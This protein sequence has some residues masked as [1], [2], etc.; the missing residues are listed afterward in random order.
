MKSAY[1]V[2]FFSLS[3]RSVD[4]GL[5]PFWQ[6]SLLNSAYATAL[7]LYASESVARFL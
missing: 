4:Q 1:I 2:S 3:I 7:L 6:P 5:N